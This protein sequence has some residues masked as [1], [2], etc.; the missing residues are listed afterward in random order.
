M[1]INLKPHKTIRIAVSHDVFLNR[2]ETEI[3][4]TPEFQRL[5]KLRQL[6]SSDLVFPT[7]LHN[8]FVHSLG[9]MQMASKMVRCIRENR[10]NKGDANE[11]RINKISEE[12][13]QLVRLVALLHDIGHLPYGHTIED[14]FNIFTRHDEDH[15]R[16]DR[17]IGRESNIGKI[18]RT[19]P[20]SIGEDLYAELFKLLTTTKETQYKLGENLFIY[21]IVNNTVCADLL[22]YLQRDSYFCDL[23]VGLDYRFLNYLYLYED[24]MTIPSS[25]N[26]LEKNKPV[27]SLF[28]DTKDAYE[29]TAETNLVSQPRTNNTEKVRV[30]RTAIRLSNKK[31]DK[32]RP[33]LLNELVAL[34]EYRYKLGEIVYFHHTKLASGS[35][36]AGAVHRAK[37]DG[38]IKL[39]DLYEMGD[40]KLI[41]TLQEKYKSVNKGNNPVKKLVDAFEKRNIWKASGFVISRAQVDK[42]QLEYADVNLLETIESRYYN[43]FNNRQK[44]EKE[45]CEKYG[46]QDGD[47][48]IHCPKN[49]MQLKLAKMNVFWQGKHRFLEDCEHN[50]IIKQ[51][52]KLI[53][54]SHR[55]L[56]AFRVFINPDIKHLDSSIKAQFNNELCFNINKKPA[57]EKAA[58]ADWLDYE[59]EN[60]YNTDALQHGIFKKIRMEIEEQVL[61]DTKGNREISTLQNLVEEI[62]KKNGVAKK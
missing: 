14:E 12:Q 33:D 52:L 59:I 54:E 17:L 32:P 34:L 40:E 25:K 7:A 38:K 62:C 21:D 31:G 48:L 55:A 15:L 1:G 49:N 57:K 43:D 20:Y 3:I 24:E 44:V 53:Q 46:L 28:P 16:I 8:R 42:E 13:E 36:I 41:Y 5:R 4:D 37:I 26:S 39:E 29:K 11:E 27:I 30:K 58:L 60:K 19:G 18:L 9:T 10:H 6:G 2:L 50:D 45:I 56:W 61:V 35:M 47:V 22:D 23:P 51:K